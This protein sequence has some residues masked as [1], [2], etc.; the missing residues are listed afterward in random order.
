M[1]EFF[2]IFYNYVFIIELSFAIGILTFRQKRRDK[3]ALR[4]VLC[5][6]LLFAV[7]SV[8]NR[9]ASTELNIAFVILRYIVLFG[10]SVAAIYILFDGSIIST[11][12]YGTCAYALQHIAYRLGDIFSHLI[13]IGRTEIPMWLHLIGEIIKFVVVII[14]YVLYA[15][16]LLKKL[17]QKENAL[18]KNK[19]VIIVNFFTI[20]IVTCLSTAFNRFVKEVGD[21]IWYI[22][23]LYAVAGSSAILFSL[24]VIARNDDLKTENQTL[25]RMLQ[26]KGQQYEFSKETIETINIKC[27]DMK[28]KISRLKNKVDAKE[29]SEL[30]NSIN[31]YD[32]S[33]KT[34][35][36]A[37][38][39]VLTEKGLI[40]QPQ[41]IR[42][43]CIAD[44]GLLSFMS[45]VDIYSLFGNA[46]DNAISAVKDLP[47]DKRVIDIS[48][49]EAMGMCSV[50]FENWYDGEL[51]FNNDLPLTTQD[52]KNYHG[53][54]L[55]S[56]KRTVE[57]YNGYMK[58][59][60]ENGVFKLNL[61]FPLN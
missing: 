47:E 58:I 44:G 20:I 33:V 6:V 38:D 11:V 40:C 22:C 51:V 42:F 15:T 59:S 16:L 1:R 55:K 19:I 34:G 30:E 25:E 3:F 41:N 17:N 60:A 10:M 26:L 24:H 14:I 32:L 37:L 53:Y 31:I 12:F 7:S 35:N 57:K 49:K 56:V 48:I 36:N 27:H 4:L 43:S 13:F 45:D 18:R 28:H 21:A 54:G 2:N 8:W 5:A 50:H 39:I 23:S 46:I 61:S 52:D 9:E 29:I